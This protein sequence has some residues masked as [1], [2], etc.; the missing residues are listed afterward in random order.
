MQEACGPRCTIAMWQHPSNPKDGAALLFTVNSSLQ[1]TSWQIQGILNFTP[2][3]GTS[4]PL[5]SGASTAFT[6]W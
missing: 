3:D 4:T 2:T 1:L 5:Q 6:T